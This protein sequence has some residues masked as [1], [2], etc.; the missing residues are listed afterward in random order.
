MHT[1]VLRQEENDTI[2]VEI[3]PLGQG[4]W[5]GKLVVNLESKKEIW[6]LFHMKA[7]THIRKNS[8]HIT[9]V[10]KALRATRHD[11]VHCP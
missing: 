4:C 11:K 3:D 9:K 8:D 2:L 10:E 6:S 1:A 5:R 7:K